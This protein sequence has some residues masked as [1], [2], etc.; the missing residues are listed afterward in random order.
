M[1]FSQ[2]EIASFSYLKTRIEICL[3]G[4]ENKTLFAHIKGNEDKLHVI[5]GSVLVKDVVIPV[6]GIL[7]PPAKEV[8]IST[9][10]YEKE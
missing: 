9:V 7:P 4:F 5:N 10:L 8:N 2:I 3:H 6:K 1:I